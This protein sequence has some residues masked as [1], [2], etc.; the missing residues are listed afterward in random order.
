MSRFDSFDDFSLQDLISPPQLQEMQ[1]SFSEVANVAIRTLGPSGEMATQT[2]SPPSLCSEIFGAAALKD[3]LCSNCRPAFLGGRGIVDEELSFECLPGLKNYLVP[4]KLSISENTSKVLGYMIIGP[5]IFMKRR[6]KEEY[7][8]LAVQL[9]VDLEQLWSFV[10][11]LRVF[12]YKGIHS[13]L[14]MVGNLM[15][16]I[17]NLAY[18]ARSIEREMSS[19]LK[20]RPP[21]VSPRNAGQLKD[22]LEMFLDLIADMTSV[23]SSSIMLLDKKNR[24]LVI[25][26]FTGI[27][28]DVA[29]TTS[30]KMGEGV[31]CLAAMTKKTY[32][33][34][35]EH[36]D[37]EISDRLNRPDLL[38]AIVVPI[39][40]QDEVFGVL[41]VSR[42]RSKSE[43][44]REEDMVL[45]TKAAGLAGM[46]LERLQS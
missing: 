40:S 37:V 38:S 30:L 35:D 22:F 6:G 2:S 26:A 21:R 28:E 33:I 10:L 45:L 12:S 39:R 43:A 3:D 18:S 20:T 17:L 24:V 27:P 44:F 23:T 1:D 13:F 29:R 9:G 36:R 46:A 11:E 25:R 34:S 7:R 4:L 15:N 16:H 42:D 32:L 14:E 19:R 8:S 31:A 41:N 5:V